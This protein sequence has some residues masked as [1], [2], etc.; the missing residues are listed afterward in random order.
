MSSRLAGAVAYAASVAH[1]G[2][3]YQRLAQNGLEQVCGFKAAI[4]IARVLLQA[5]WRPMHELKAVGAPTYTRPIGSLL[6]HPIK[7]IIHYDSPPIAKMLQL[8]KYWFSKAIISPAALPGTGKSL[9]DS[10]LLSR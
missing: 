5:A 10:G 3:R 7:L 9:A 6:N 2:G 1:C 4:I 8:H